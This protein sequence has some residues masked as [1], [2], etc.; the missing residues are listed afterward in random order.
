MGFCPEGAVADAIFCPMLKAIA[1]DRV[2]RPDVRLMQFVSAQ[3]AWAVDSMRP[4]TGEMFVRID[5]ERI[6]ISE[7]DGILLRGRV[8]PGR[9]LTVFEGGD[10]CGD[11]DFAADGEIRAAFVAVKDLDSAR[12]VRGSMLTMA[13]DFTSWTLLACLDEP[14]R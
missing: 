13:E 6:S 11:S 7:R 9:P 2:S 4:P 1:V 14:A 10:S 5:I 8:E 12:R 3:A